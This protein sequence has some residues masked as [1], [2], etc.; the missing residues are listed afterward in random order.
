MLVDSHC[1]P[2]F[3]QLADEIPSMLVR[4]KEAGVGIAVAICTNWDETETLRKMVCEHDE[5]YAT[6][7]IHP[8]TDEK[9]ECNPDRLAKEVRSHE[10]FVA[11]GECG[12]DYHHNEKEK[13]RGWQL[14]RMMTQAEVALATKKP[15]VVH[16]R[17]SIDDAISDLAPLMRKG[18][19]AVLHCFSGGWEQAKKALDTG[20]M[21]SFTGNV[22]FNSARD[23]LEVAAR[24]PVD[25]F[26]VETDAPYLAPVPH[27]GKCNEPAYVRHVL[28]C[29]AARRDVDPKDLELRT[30][31]NAL[32]FYGLEKNLS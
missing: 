26:M 10:K 18:L 2:H 31:D 25:R 30:T 19:Q 22:T 15:L 1:H 17:E 14:A 6:I 7:G 32:A 9:V 13:A 8:N 23:L 5:L 20:F 24:V 4:M 11:V 21:L 12:L 3:P 16:T 29:I 27:R 28:D